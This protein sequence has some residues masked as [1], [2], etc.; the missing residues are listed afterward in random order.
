[1]SVETTVEWVVV[2]LFA[3]D[4][5]ELILN[6]GIQESFQ[7]WMGHGQIVSWVTHQLFMP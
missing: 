1:M 3:N 4:M 2:L 5:K 6:V 7:Y